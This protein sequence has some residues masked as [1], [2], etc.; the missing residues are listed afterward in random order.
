MVIVFVEA[1]KKA[2]Y[3]AER[4]REGA[5]NKPPERNQQQPRHTNIGG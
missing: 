3:S 2:R 1:Y 5:Y 4:P